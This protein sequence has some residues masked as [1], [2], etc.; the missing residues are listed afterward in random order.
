MS[1]PKLTNST[2]LKYAWQEK[3]SRL[4]LFFSFISIIIIFILF[5]RQYPLPNF[6]PEST[7]YIENAFAN[8][9]ISTWPIG[10][11]I[12]LRVVSCFTNSDNIFIFIQY[13]LLQSAII[14]LLLTIHFLL[15]PGKWIMRILFVALTI[16]PLFF[17]TANIISADAFFAALSIIWITQLIWIIYKPSIVLIAIHAAILTLAFMSHHNGRWYPLVSFVVLVLIRWPLKLKLKGLAFVILLPLAFIGNALYYYKKDTGTMQAFGMDGWQLAN[18]ALYAYFYVRPIKPEAVPP[19]FRPLHKVIN[20]HMD[21]IRGMVLRPDTL[22]GNYYASDSTSPLKKYVQ[23]KY[24]KDTTS[25]GLKRWAGVSRLYSNYG[26]Y[27]IKQNSSVFIEQYLQRNLVHYYAPP[28]EFLGSY[29]WTKDS[30]EPVIQMWFKYPP[31]KVSVYQPVKYMRKAP[32]Y[33][34]II[35]TLFLVSFLSFLFIG[36]SKKV[37]ANYLRVILLIFFVWLVNLLFSVFYAPILL[38]QQVFTVVLEF[39]FGVMLLQKLIQES[40]S[41][42]VDKS[43]LNK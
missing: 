35:N 24:A 14:Y 33:F 13:L 42:P 22:L 34:G 15:N 39:I 6:L 10:Y 12:F 38:R 27:L 25:T 17:L 18:N 16:N 29:N 20:H 41:K 37:P 9:H 5:K 21:S 36:A 8:S 28:A 32:A 1:Y 40:F 4:Y 31:T 11:S 26:S 2:L 30:V 23:I 19:A 3:E 43:H 7:S